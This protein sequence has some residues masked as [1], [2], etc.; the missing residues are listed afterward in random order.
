MIHNNHLTAL[1]QKP[2][3]FIGSNVIQLPK[4]R[5]INPVI[6]MDRQY[7]GWMVE[8]MDGCRQI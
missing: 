5:Q 7:D 6:L 3:G 2:A 1:Y 4:L 8:W